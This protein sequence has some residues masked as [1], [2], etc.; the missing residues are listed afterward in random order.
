VQAGA[1]AAPKGARRAIGELVRDSQR[2]D[3]AAR[4]ARAAV[5]ALLGLCVTLGAAIANV[6]L[7]RGVETSTKLPYVVQASGRE[8]ATNVD[9]LMFDPST[10]DAVA[11]ALKEA[12][13]RLRATAVFVGA[14]RAAAGSVCLGAI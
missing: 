8:L 11:A 5:F 2:D 14:H 4:L 6:Y 7:H 13:V 3:D 12:G 9:F 1:P 10:Y